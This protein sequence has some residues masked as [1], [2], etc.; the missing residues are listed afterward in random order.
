MSATDAATNQDPHWS[1]IQELF[2]RAIEL[3]EADR[4]EFIDRECGDEARLRAELMDLLAADA[5]DSSHRL[6]TNA[7]GAAIDATTR[8]RREA[9]I[10]RVLGNY[11]LTAVLGHGGAGTVYLAERA[12]RQYSA[13]V[14]IKVLDATTM[15]GD[16]RSRFRAERQILASLNHPN[17]A[18]LLDAGE[19]QEGQPYLVM[20]YVHGETLDRYCDRRRLD[21]NARLQLLLDICN[22]V[23]YAHQNLVVHRDLKPANILV[24]ENGTPKLLDFG[25]AKLLEVGEEAPIAL[26]RMNDRLLTPEYASPEQILGRPVTT[27]SDVYALGVVLYE[28][29]TGLRPYTVSTSASQLEL[30]RSICVTD[31]VRPSAAVA[32]A[33]SHA[34]GDQSEVQA[35]AAARHLTPEKLSRKLIG[36]IEAIIM[37]ALRKEPE[38]RYGSVEQLAEDIRRYLVREPVKARHG[39]W[40]Y[41]SQRFARRHAF[42]VAAGAAFILFTIAFAIA[43]SVQRQRIAAERDRAEQEGQRAETVSEFMLDVFSAADPFVRPGEEVTARELL[44]VAA[45]RINADLSPQPEV[46]AR[47][48]E[49]IGR[50]YRRQHLY[51]RAIGHLQEALHIRQKLPDAASAKT[52]S[53][54][55]ELAITLRQAGDLDAADD[56]LRDAVQLA[57]AHGNQE[58]RTYAQLLANLGRMQLQAGDPGSARTYFEQS[59]ELTRRI[60]G[61]NDPDAAGLLAELSAVALWFDD[62]TTAERLAR[63]AVEIYRSSVHRLH[64]DRVVAEVRLAETLQS[65]GRFNEAEPL[66]LSALDNQE[67]VYGSRSRQ[68]ADILDSLASIKR[69]QG[70]LLEAKAYGT[71]AVAAQNAALGADHYMTAYYRTGLAAVLIQLREY[72]GAERELRQALDIYERTLPP[73]HQYIAS[74]EHLLGELLLATNRISDA[75]PVLR[76]AMNRWTRSDAPP[77]RSARSAS[78]LGQALYQAGRIQEA[79]RLLVEGYRTLALDKTADRAARIAAQERITRFYTAMGRERDLQ[80]LK[81]EVALAH[82]QPRN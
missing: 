49:A 21:L 29:M 24:T 61:P 80:R 66:F 73:D 46:R 77:W 14:A 55:A 47:L 5:R 6:L 70:L 43:M 37:R 52:A 68:M 36:D 1:R 53:V 15:H 40:L 2:A 76:A 41:Y 30:E 48:L 10:G 23:Q 56:A 63:Q 16:L 31:P 54:L 11:R 60:A 50:A 72:S 42:G 25:I 19:T 12:D 13:Q 34:S 27:A 4:P 82:D 71:R 8:D 28:L 44:D 74:S 69:S 3:P 7:L 22:A 20:E 9:L 26:T 59:L 79:E 33:M 57:R 45:A 65:Q 18:R 67:K 32:G 35:I 38:R 75:E 51:D 17:I 58:S 78:A 39:N 62:S 81:A 64:P